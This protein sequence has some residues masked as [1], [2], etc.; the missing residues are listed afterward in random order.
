MSVFEYNSQRNDLIIP[1][2]GRHVQKMIEFAKTISGERYLEC[3]GQIHLYGR[4]MAAFFQDHDI[5]LTPTMAEPPAK[6]GRFSHD[7]TDYEAYRTGPDGVFAYSPFAAAFNASGQPAASVPLHWTADGLPC[8]IHLA[9]AYGEDA[10]LMSLCADLER[11]LP[12]SDRRP[13]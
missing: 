2:Y 11:A 13:A 9:A 1:E 5:L 10:L 8:G 6:N 3:V 7:R 4:Q 12:W